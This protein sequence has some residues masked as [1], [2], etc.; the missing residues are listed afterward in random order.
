[1]IKT[2][3][4][5]IV[6]VTCV[7]MEFNKPECLKLTGNIAENFKLFKE[8]VSVFFE[9]TETTS[10]PVKVQVARLLNLIGSDGVKI[11]RTFNIDHKD[12]TV[13]IIFN[14]LE[15]YCTPKK[16]E[17]MEHYKFFNR[18][19]DS[20]ESF[21]KF[22]AD[23]RSLI[24]SC[25]F[26]EAENKLLRTQIVLGTND[27]NLQSKLLS[28]DLGLEKVVRHCQVTEQSKINT[29]IIIQENENKIDFIEQRKQSKFDNSKRSEGNGRV[30]DNNSNSINNKIK[31]MGKKSR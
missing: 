14:K 12:E 1:M 15:E 17:V 7:T 25:G 5:S 26:G 4:N 27:K 3:K 29:N 18:K 31:L 19:Q 28:E 23:L 9:A 2:D 10:K 20:N 30:I 22:Y 8:E 24:N 11:Y 6:K 21:D 16:N 13:D